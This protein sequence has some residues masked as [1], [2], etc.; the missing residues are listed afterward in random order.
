ML[1]W[2]KKKETVILCIQ[3]SE[4]LLEAN[5]IHSVRK[6]GFSFGHGSPEITTLFLGSSYRGDNIITHQSNI[7]YATSVRMTSQIANEIG[8]YKL[9]FILSLGKKPEPKYPKSEPD[10]NPQIPKW[11]QELYI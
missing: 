10:R 8:E 5:T 11:F 6:A 2:Y 1:F 7:T 9:I 4:S 3:T